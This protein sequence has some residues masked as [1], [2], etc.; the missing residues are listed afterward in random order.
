M[1]KLG[2][3]YSSNFPYRIL[4]KIYFVW[5]LVSNPTSDYGE[6]GVRLG[7][8]HTD[9]LKQNP[10]ENL[11]MTTPDVTRKSMCPTEDEERTDRQG[12]TKKKPSRYLVRPSS[13]EP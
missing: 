6:S 4:K 8:S 7:P 12:R 3:P 1:N 5:A 10:H 13:K 11:Q 9:S 2:K